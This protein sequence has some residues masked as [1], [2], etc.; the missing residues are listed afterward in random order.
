MPVVLSPQRRILSGVAPRKIGNQGQRHVHTGQNT[1]RRVDVPVLDP[2][3][4]TDPI[5]FRPL[6]AH[7]PTG[8]LG[9]GDDLKV[10]GMHA[11]HLD[12]SEHVEDLKPLEQ[13]QSHF[14]ALC[15][16]HEVA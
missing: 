4:L 14:I 7:D 9:N 2:T 6:G 13:D 1:G 8:M 16:G 12:G 3:S 11:E 15:R 5:H 10:V